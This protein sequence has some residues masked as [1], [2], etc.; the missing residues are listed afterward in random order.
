MCF[1]P[2]VLYDN[3]LR[4]DRLQIGNAAATKMR[5]KL[6]QSPSGR[7]LLQ[8]KPTIST[9]TLNLIALRGKDIRGDI[10]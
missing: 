10:P 8:N 5:D 9:T 7:I 6:R 1:S 4:T 2:F 3:T